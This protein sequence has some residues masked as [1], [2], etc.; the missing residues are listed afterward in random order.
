MVRKLQKELQYYKSLLT[1][2]AKGSLEVE[3]LTLKKENDKLKSIHTNINLVEQ[4]KQENIKMKKQLQEIR[5]GGADTSNQRQTLYSDRNYTDERAPH[6]RESQRTASNVI[7]KIENEKL[8]NIKNRAK[9]YSLQA[10]NKNRCPI[11]T[12]PLP[13]KHYK[14]IDEFKVDLPACAIKILRPVYK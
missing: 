13:C 3:L 7:E 9:Q 10:I 6:S 12:L 5:S 1:Y 8:S 2:K 4:L 14:T 11:C